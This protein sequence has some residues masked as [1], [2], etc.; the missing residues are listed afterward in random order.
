MHQLTLLL[1]R[2][3]DVEIDASTDTVTSKAECEEKAIF[4]EI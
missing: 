4:R 2:R 3:V 1:Q